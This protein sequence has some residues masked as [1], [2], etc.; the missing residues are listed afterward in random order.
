MDQ[1]WSPEQPPEWKG[2]PLGQTPP[3][4]PTPPP[5][6]PIAPPASSGPVPHRPLRFGEILSS[7]WALFQLRR[8]GF[9]RAALLGGLAAAA[10]LLASY[11]P[12]YSQFGDALLGSNG[13]LNFDPSKSN[14]IDSATLAEALTAMTGLGIAN[15]LAQTWL[16]ALCGALAVAAIRSQQQP[17]ASRFLRYLWT[18]LVFG[19]LLLACAVPVVAVSAAAGSGGMFIIG[20]TTSLCL[21]A[22]LWLALGSL[23]LLGVV[24]YEGKSGLAAI[25][26]SL[27]L[28]NGRRFR[29][30]WPVL[31]VSALAGIIGQVVASI[32]SLVPSDNLTGA[33]IAD[34]LAAA[35][36]LATATPFVAIASILIYVSRRLEVEPPAERDLF[37]Q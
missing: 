24:L 21:A 27:R 20:L 7:T 18:E 28:A 8:S 36:S 16:A 2:T 34:A 15:L 31:V 4:S 13:L 29:M 25:R 26:Q 14:S 3:S 17:G 32:A 37:G 6:P 10:F 23:P 30:F 33:A 1:H 9:L 19:L 11:L 12:I 22:G 35:V 5:A